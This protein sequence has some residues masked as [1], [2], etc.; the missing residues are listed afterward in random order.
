[1][2]ETIGKYVIEKKL[3][4]G[5]MGIVYKCLDPENNRPVAVKV[6]P[7]QLASDAAFLQRFKREV[8][9][10]RRLGHPNIVKMYD[11][12][13][14]DASFY[15]A[16]EYAEGKSLEDV[17]ARKERMP[18][19]RAMAIIRGCAEALEHSHAQGIIH[20]DIKPANIMLVGEDRV[21]L[22]DFGIAKVL[23][24]TRMTA[25]QGVLGTAEYMSPEQSEGRRVD[26]RTDIYSL[27]VVLYECLTTRVPITA[28]N[29][30][31][32]IMKLRTAQ[33]D[34]P[35]SWA[36]ELPKNLSDFVMRMLERDPAR[37]CES[38][39]ELI[40]ELD[41]IARQIQ[42]GLD[43]KGPATSTTRVI[44]TG[45]EA[46]V[47]LWRN[48]WTIVLLA[49]I[50]AAFVW[51]RRHPGSEPRPSPPP[52]VHPSAEGKGAPLANVW[53]LQANRARDRSLSEDD[54]PVERA[55]QQAIA[56]DLCQLIM[57]HFPQTAQADEA[58]VLLL[59]LEMD[60]GNGKPPLKPIRAQERERAEKLL[61]DAAA[62]RVRKEYD[63]A[64]GLCELVKQLFPDT[65]PAREA[66]IELLRIAQYE[67]HDAAGE[68]V[69]A[70][71]N[72]SPDTD[73]S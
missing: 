35:I 66:E 27:G 16:M 46:A 62:S 26:A 55:A 20:R 24:A 29:P 9:T 58:E 36:P 8:M 6:L 53:L 39:K 14:H 57:A 22:M 38:A 25:T 45:R 30:T 12:G 44:R 32:L 42:S 72:E 56:S 65:E 5:G 17:L 34:P 40:R 2:A 50:L 3:G 71:D 64:R 19:L 13:T 37:R 11:Q 48:P 21:K 33:I 60:A 59:R 63:V 23:D 49:L 73:E 43:G 70:P 54:S 7:Q 69:P 18:P 1:M 31:A 10:L 4:Q 52:T 61:R 15:Y 41:R 51:F 47:P 28:A 68:S 67:R